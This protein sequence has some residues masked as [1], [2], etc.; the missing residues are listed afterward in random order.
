MLAAIRGF[1][2]TI[3]LIIAGTFGGRFVQFMILPFL[4][5]LLHQKFG[6]NEL[7][8]G[9]FLAAASL[10]GIIFGFYVGYLSDRIGRRKI[11]LFGVV[12]TIVAM[13][14]LGM[15]DNL[16]VLF[17][18]TLMQ[19]L[20]RPMVENP[21][22]ALMTDTVDDRDVKDMALHMRYF[23]LNVGA[24]L[25]P[26]LGAA[27]GLTGEQSTFYLVAVVYCAY[28]IGAI[29]VF[30][31][32]R[33]ARDS[34]AGS[35]LNLGEVLRVLGRDR[36]FLLL[37][38]ASLICSICYGQTDSALVQYLQIQ[39][40]VD[41]ASFYAILIA[42]NAGTIVVLQFPLLRMMQSITL[43]RRS[44][45]GVILFVFGFVGFAIAPTET[46]YGLMLAMFVLSVGEAIVFPTQNLIIDRIA[47][48]AMKGSYFGAYSLG[49][50]GFAI[51]PLIGGALL[52]AFGGLVLWLMT[53]FLASIV[54]LLYYFGGQSAYKDL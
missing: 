31:I 36:P 27:A 26:L 14:A 28:L 8:V 12:L 40:V 3:W 18:G 6:L 29:A 47:P 45:I 51:A 33:P 24:A 48:D 15:A 11:I 4:A 39:S 23:G 21:G 41:I 7:E 2:L 53:A 52:Y 42:V 43:F 1:N 13:I 19:S 44:M 38:L 30:R 16:Y 25:G 54:A 49:V 37:V 5:I 50:L 34:A 32:E 46:P 10:V 9:I 22:R 17:A 35:L 20:A